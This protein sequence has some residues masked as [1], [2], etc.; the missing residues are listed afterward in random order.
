M[1]EEVS[2]AVNFLSKLLA[3]R[4]SVTGAQCSLF[5]DNL[6]RLLTAK[7]ENHWHPSKP[8][9]GNAFRCLN[10]DTVTNT[11][12]PVLVKAAKISEVSPVCLPQVFPDGLDLWIDPGDVSCRVGRGDIWPIYQCNRPLSQQ[13][14]ERQALV[15][16]QLNR[17]PNECSKY[18][19]KRGRYPRVHH[20]TENFDKYHWVRKDNLGQT[21][22]VCY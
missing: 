2:S 18:M 5:R 8:L 7:F 9:R 14:K 1:K 20:H 16:V 4:P 6:E 12:D 3:T 17:A 11:I 19:V 10:I 13:P 22:Q 15:P 21:A